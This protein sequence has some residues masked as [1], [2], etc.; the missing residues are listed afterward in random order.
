[1]TFGQNLGKYLLAASCAAAVSAHSDNLILEEVIVTATKRAESA[2]DIPMS[3]EALS[4]DML[5]NQGVADM[6]DMA[7][8]VPNLNIGTGLG[9]TFIN[10]RGM[11]SGGDRSFE[12]SVGLFVDNIYMPRSAHYRSAFMDVERVEVLRGTQAVLFGLNSTAGAISIHSARNRPGDA[13]EALIRVEYETEYETTTTDIAVGGGVTDTLGLRFAGKFSEGDSYI[14]HTSDGKPVGDKDLGIARLSVVWEPTNNLTVEGKIE[15]VENDASGTNVTPFTQPGDY[16]LKTSADN[17]LTSTIKNATIWRKKPYA[18]RDEEGYWQEVDN[19]VLKVDY[20]MSGYTLTG[21]LGYSDMTDESALDLD[22]GALPLFWS[23]TIQ[24]YE[25]SSLELRLASPVESDFSYIVGA[26]YQEANMHND[27]ANVLHRPLLSGG[28]LPELEWTEAGTDQESELYSLFATATWEISESMRL[29]SGIRYVNETKEIE[30]YGISA[31]E[32]I[33][34]SNL[35]REPDPATNP[36]D[37]ILLFP[38]T[39]DGATGKR[40]SENVMPEMML[41]VDITEQIMTY[42]KLGSSAKGGGFAGSLNLP[43]LDKLEFDDENAWGIELGM[44]AN[45]ADG[46]AELNVAAFYTEYD[47]LQVNSFDPTTASASTTNA[48]SSISQGIEV[49]GR[50]RLTDWLLIGGSVAY[51]DAY[52]DEFT[53]GPTN[54]ASA[55]GADFEDL[56]GKSTPFSAEWSGNLFTDATFPLNDAV[57]FVGGIKVSFSGDYYT[58]GPLDPLGQQDVW[59]KVDARMGVAAQDDSW[60]LMIIG[61]N[62]TDELTNNAFQAFGGANMSFLSP[63]KTITI[64]G[65]YRFGH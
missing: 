30:R 53:E 63:P 62:L 37:A 15:H 18:E 45:L 54:S 28:L 39:F 7:G 1:M 64:Q 47:D 46:A 5:V 21:L 44:K 59:V 65:E 58:D 50:W 43:S 52:Y 8:S 3:I 49:D 38:P 2:Q 24:E 22:A 10:V 48:G 25:Q 9:Q 34:G 17:L 61:K 16:T 40:T 13:L 26:Y 55:P 12:Q 27:T 6:A 4:G 42:A 57:N 33:P 29:T 60:K 14:E 51:L 20:D 32:T 36:T 23:T 19:A 11:G 35:W 31:L 41:Q 56:S